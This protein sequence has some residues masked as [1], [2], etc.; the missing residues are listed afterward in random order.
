MD[1]GMLSV[2]EHDAQ[3]KAVKCYREGY[4]KNYKSVHIRALT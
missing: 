2:F 1:T 4:S 3:K